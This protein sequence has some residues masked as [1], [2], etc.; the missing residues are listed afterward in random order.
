MLL[1]KII[2]KTWHGEHA[3][4]DKLDLDVRKRKKP[5]PIPAKPSGPDRLPLS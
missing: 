1:P 5:D 2:F 4:L 3:Q